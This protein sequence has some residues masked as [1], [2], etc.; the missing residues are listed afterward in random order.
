MPNVASHPRTHASGRKHRTNAEK[1]SLEAAAKALERTKPPRLTAPAWLNPKA[2]TIWKRK[3]KEIAG[4]NS[5]DVL[6]D[7]L[8]SDV[9]AVF[10]DNLASYMDLAKKNGKTSLEEHK[11][12]QAY[13]LRIIGAAERLGFTPASRARLIRKNALDENG[14]PFGEEFD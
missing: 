12:K 14:D 7:T 9:F 4:L 13:T 11:I 3:V 10:C 8:D 6:L 5:P 1:D 2:Q